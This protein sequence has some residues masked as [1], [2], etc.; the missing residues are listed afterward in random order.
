MATITQ[1]AD[2]T[3]RVRIRR[4][5]Y[6]PISRNFTKKAHAQRWAT[7]TEFE[8]DC[9]TF[10][11]EGETQNVLLSE[12]ID[13]YLAEIAPTKKSYADIKSRCL[14][15]R[16]NF[17]HYSLSS[18]TPAVIKSYRD[19]RLL[20]RHS[21]SVRKE[22][23][24]LGRI[25][26]AA[27]REWDVT[28]PKSNPVRR[29]AIP[30]K[31][32]G[33]DRRLLPGEERILIEESQRYGGFIA[34]I[35]QFAIET[36]MR[37]GEIVRLQWRDVDFERRVAKLRDTKNGFDRVIPLS[38]RALEILERQTSKRSGNVFSICADSIT[39]AF[40]RVID[41]AGLHDLRFHDLRHE[42]ASR[43]FE[44]G[45]SVMEVSSITG[46]RDLASLKRYTHL[47]AEDLAKK[48]A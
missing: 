10:N 21:D 2:G 4:Q 32:R 39:K 34:D 1:T 18:L 15:L 31:G 17:G 37:R 20:I 47:R 43:F 25:L 48:L 46:H 13:R 41:R 7:Q 30:R 42:A 19:K 23:L 6:P 38:S 3:Y 44:L 35:I 11:W 8:I 14:L 40:S 22:L 45:L 24:L 36:G 12:L 33:R 29:L 5:G 9:G 26:T 27:E 16:Q 28:L